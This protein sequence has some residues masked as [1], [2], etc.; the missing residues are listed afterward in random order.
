MNEQSV[1]K[2]F[3]LVIWFLIGAAVLSATRR[4]LL[5]VTESMSKDESFKNEVL[6]VLTVPGLAILNVVM[7]II[8]CMIWPLSLIR[9]FQRR[10]LIN[11]H[12]AKN[13]PQRIL[14]KK[15]DDA[16]RNRYKHGACTRRTP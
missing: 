6:P 5:D 14:I 8:C 11:G 7:W 3:I 15:H 16:T 2:Y 9:F 1:I 12:I 10:G 13:C 4:G